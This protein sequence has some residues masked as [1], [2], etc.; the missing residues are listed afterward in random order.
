MCDNMC[1]CGVGF[2]MSDITKHTATVK[3]YFPPVPSNVY[4][5]KTQKRQSLCTEILVY[6]LNAVYMYV[7]ALDCHFLKILILLLWS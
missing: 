6:A 4:H 3:T 5:S 1:A 2:A 7:W